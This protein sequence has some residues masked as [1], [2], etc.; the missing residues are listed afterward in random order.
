M[1]KLALA[2]TAGGV[3]GAL[4]LKWYISTH[5]GDTIVAALGDKIFGEGSTG[6]RV[7]RGIGGALDSAVN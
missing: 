2:F 6:A 4:L 1:L 5:P 7:V 3:A